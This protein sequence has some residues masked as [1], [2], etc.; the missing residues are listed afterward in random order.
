MVPVDELNEYPRRPLRRNPIMLAVGIAVIVGLLVYLFRPAG[1]SGSDRS[2]PDFDL[3]LLS[4]QSTLH[5]EELQGSPVVFNFFASWCEP[6]RDEAPLLERAWRD[7]RSR[8]VRFVGVNMQDTKERARSFV[9]E[10]GI[11][12]PVVTDYD[13]ELA[14]GLNVYGLP[15][16]F[17]VDRSWE[18]SSIQAGRKVGSQGQTAKL[19]AI[20]AAELRDRID[21]MLAGGE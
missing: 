21:E 12:Y 20:S 11:T 14:R 1:E 19:G 17:F 9:D 3:P 10:F 6:C 7:Y 15:Q 4:G 13:Q 2:V 8:G 16:T 18:L 5:S